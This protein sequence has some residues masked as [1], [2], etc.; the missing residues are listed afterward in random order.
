MDMQ[1]PQLRKLFEARVPQISSLLS[2][3]P[4]PELGSFDPT[5][6]VLK[7]FLLALEGMLRKDDLRS[8]PFTARGE[9]FDRIGRAIE[10]M[11]ALPESLNR[12]QA[13]G[14]LRVMDGLHRLCLRETSPATRMPWL[15]TKLLPTSWLFSSASPIR[16]C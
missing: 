4:P 3:D 9:L 11:E 12:Q 16:R 14:V 1:I 13:F 5:L 15:C 8:L 7:G 2:E 6:R 10:A